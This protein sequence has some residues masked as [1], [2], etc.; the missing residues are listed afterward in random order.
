MSILIRFPIALLFIAFAVL[1]LTA[2][3]GGVAFVLWLLS[4]LLRGAL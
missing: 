2:V 4:G 3:I 1:V